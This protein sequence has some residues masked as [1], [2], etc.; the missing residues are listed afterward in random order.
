MSRTAIISVDGHVKASR[1]QY[2]DYVEERFR[3]DFDAWKKGQ[4][5]AGVPDV[6]NINPEFGADSQWDSKKRMADLESIGVVAEV[7]FT[8]GQPFQVNPFDDF[9]RGLNPELQE[10][11]RRAY[12]RWLADFCS[13]AP[14]RRRGQMSMSFADIDAAVKDVYW[15]K[16]HGLGGIA[17]PGVNPG[18]RFLFDPALDPIWAAIQEV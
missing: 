5:D 17:L 7:L 13:E 6:G 15:A 9:A 18:D 8:N 14:D 11:G 3:E 16:E 1:E 10:E 2:R 12:N 4:E